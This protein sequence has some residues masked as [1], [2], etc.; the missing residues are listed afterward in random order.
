[1]RLF[2]RNNGLSLV[3][4]ALFLASIL[5]HWLTGW[6]F[7]NA[8]LVRHGEPG[9]TL[10]QYTTNAQFI[11]TIFENWESEFLQMSAYVLLTSW[12]FQKGSAE[13]ADPAKAPRDDHLAA[14]ARR[15]DAPAILRRGRIARWVYANSLGLVLLL[16]FVG[17][18]LL[19]WKY[20]AAQAAEEA[21]SHGERPL[22]MGE[23]LFDA[24]LW[25]ES[26]QNWQSE[27]LS[28]AVL[29]LLTIFLRQRE[30]PESKPVAAPHAQ[31]AG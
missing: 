13:S 25:F 12:L 8:E 5:G 6:R 1:M 23:Y 31:T 2:F 19:H 4:L 20:S 29:V 14:Q 22:S 10:A 7:E 24:Q 27:F 28:T 26:F 11:S 17:S 9:L 3:L 15:K 18:F 21:I 16:L 30:S